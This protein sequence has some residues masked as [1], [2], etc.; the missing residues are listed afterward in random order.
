MAFANQAALAIRNARI[1]ERIRNYTIEL[2]QS[3]QAR[4]AQLRAVLEAM[5]DGL[6]YRDLSGTPQYINRALTELTG[7][8]LEDWR[9]QHL[10]DV[11]AV[12]S[13]EERAQIAQRLQRLLE[14]QNYVEEDMEIQRKNGTTFTA[15]LT[16]VYVLDDA[17]NRIGT[18]TLVRDISQAKQLEEQ[19]ARFIANASHELRTP[20]ANIKTRLFLMRRQ[21]ERF[22]EHI[23]IAEQVTRYMQHLV[24][25]MFDLARFERGVMQLN[26]E[27]VVIQELVNS[28]IQNLMPEAE[29]K[30]IA[31]L[32]TSPVTPITLNVDVY[33]L[34]QVLNNLLTNALSHTPPQGKIEVSI[35]PESDN[36]QTTHVKLSVADTG[37]GIAPEH[38]AQLFKPFYRASHNTQ[39]AGLG[40][41]ISREI[42]Q[43]HGGDIS[44]ESEIGVG[45]RFTVRLP[46]EHHGETKQA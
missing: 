25:D 15:R 46:F 41:S 6:I 33:R 30:S 13:D 5:R 18:L 9:V 19:K 40:L 1:L 42:V 39:G 44:V 17:K 32:H 20:I 12:G 29:R 14:L 43:L 21:P 35:T 2:E 28:A 34:L 10:D 22:T 27:P 37:T 8:E 16:K 3:V 31:L 26:R 4:T 36:G 7:Y 11:L 23:D 45:T 24:E 38:M